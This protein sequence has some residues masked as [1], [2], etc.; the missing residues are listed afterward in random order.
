MPV[1]MMPSAG[2]DMK[3]SRKTKTQLIEE[4]AALR[5]RVAAMEE[6][7]SRLRQSAEEMHATSQRLKFHMEKAPFAVIEWDPCYRVICWSDEAEKIFGWNAREILGKSFDELCM[8]YEED[9]NAVLLIMEEIMNGNSPQSICR[10]R[11]YR[12][13]GTVIHCEWYNSV[14]LDSSGLLVSVLSRVLDITARVRMEEEL[15]VSR[16]HLADLV[17]KRTRELRTTCET[18]RREIL[19]HRL[20][21]E[22]LRLFKALVNW[23][24]DA[25]YLVDPGTAAIL[26]CN[27]KGFRALGYTKEELLRLKIFHCRTYTPFSSWECYIEELRARESLT[28]ETLHRRKDGTLFPV[29][30]NAK[31]VAHQGK[32]YI[33]SVVRDI[34]DR[35][36]AEDERARLVAALDSIADAI[37][38]TDTDWTVQYVNPGFEQ[39]TGYSRKEVVGRNLHLLK[40]DE[41]HELYREIGNALLRGEVWRG[42]MKSRK[43]DGTLYEEDVAF[44]PVRGMFEQVLGYVAVKRD[45]TEKVRLEAIV[46]AV[47]T[48]NNIGYI[49]SGIRHEIGNP[50]NSMRAALTV[51]R[52]RFD[53]LDKE[54]V[55]AYLDRSLGEI[56]RVEY[57]LKSLKSFNMHEKLEARDFDLVTFLNKFLVLVKDDF[58]KKGIPL[59]MFV[60]PEVKLCHADP[61]ALQQV[62]LNILTNAADACAGEEDPSIYITLLKVPRMVM[63]R[64]ADTGIG[65]TEEQQKEIFNPFYTTKAHGTGLGLVIVRK[66]LA[67]MNGTI[68]VLS[69]KGE[70]T[71][72]NILLPEGKDER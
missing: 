5:G 9:R 32:Y 46:E 20:T 30:V 65:M 67:K 63:I 15:R 42:R 35:K 1:L 4:I 72:V 26:D 14:L 61:R 64:I 50:L 49:F 19:G 58:M 55:G 54:A 59:T 60:G 71:I 36:R 68:K 16:G 13:D 3:D 21:D 43:K 45:I 28:F 39:V 52:D 57:L 7:E 17:E 25:I 53:S 12:K 11:N 23:S 31:Y 37:A 29:E 51:V 40:E 48:M 56:S 38:V 70:G 62:L 44:S 18:L 10:N 69:R 22:S 27:D 33:I 2:L 41:Q 47:N 8:V 6:S 24:N 34:T 66:M